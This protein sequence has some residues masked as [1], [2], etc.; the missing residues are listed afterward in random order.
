[1]TRNDRLRDLYNAI[2]NLMFENEGRPFEALSDEARARAVQ[3]MEA[4]LPPTAVDPPTGQPFAIVGTEDATNWID[5][6]RTW[7]GINFG[8]EADPND[9][10]SARYGAFLLSQVVAHRGHLA[11]QVTTLQASN[12]ALLL[13][14]RTMAAVA[15]PAEEWT[16]IGALRNGAM[17]LTRDG[18]LA[19]KSEYTYPNG[20]CQ[21]TLLASGEYGHFNQGT[22]DVTHND[23]AVV[24]IEPGVKR[25]PVEI[26]I[27]HM[28]TGWYASMPSGHWELGS[29]PNEA[30]GKLVVSHH[31]ALNIQLTRTPT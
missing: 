26:K 24:E 2:S 15:R 31:K 9:T 22:E 8:S 25:E 30:L 12:T 3:M 13:R 5:R 16:T 10:Y 28:E 20:G 4:A 6:L 27:Q 21:V 17:F 29:G 7:C 18:V 11:K 23:V 14:C 19:V 1:M